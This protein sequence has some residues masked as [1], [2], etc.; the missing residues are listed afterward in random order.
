MCEC[1]RA[2]KR[3]IDRERKRERES[4]WGKDNEMNPYCLNLLIMIEILIKNEKY[5]KHFLEK[6]YYTF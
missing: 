2:R 5:I 3:E 1:E 4:E 6:L